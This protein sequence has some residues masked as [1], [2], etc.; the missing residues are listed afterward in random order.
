MKKLLALLAVLAIVLTTCI[1]GI[2][3]VASAAEESPEADFVVFDGILEEYLGVGGDVVIPASLG[4]TEIAADC[5]RLCSEI[6]SIVIPEGVEVIGLRAFWTCENLQS[7]T[8]PYSLYEIGQEAFLSSALTEITIP[9]QVEIV[10]YGCF[11]GSYFLSE[12]KFSYGVERIHGGAFGGSIATK[13]IFP[14]TVEFIG[15]VA[16]N[17]VR[18]N[19]KVEWIICNPD[20]EIGYYALGAGLEKD[21]A[22]QNLSDRPMRPINNTLHPGMNV[23]F[24]VPRDSAIG[25]FIDENKD[26]MLD[27]S[28]QY[29]DAQA[30]AGTTY[31]VSYKDPSYFKDLEENQKGYGIKEP[32]SSGNGTT[33]DTTPEQGDE[34]GPGEEGDKGTSG[35]NSN[36]NNNNKNNGGN[37]TYIEQEKDNSS[38][39]MVLAIVGGVILLIIIG[40]VVFLVIYM[41]KPKA[42]A[43]PPYGYPPYGYPPVGPDGQPIQYAPQAPVAPAP[44]AAP[45]A[46]PVEEAPV[47]ETP[48]EE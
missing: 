2:G 17:Y 10:P 25:K 44:E 12:I 22:N 41:K 45:E 23:T 9:P 47:D 24:T 36:K 31:R 35:S 20:C 8:L 6:T 28:N 33:G 34:Y 15:G 42:P 46:A 1:M 18:S 7:V 14:E 11:Q 3:T 37:T 5:F 43:Y 19:G 26:I 48:T 27:R 29:G 32:A 16:F 21:W 13:V 39:I 30:G 4:V 38:M 40:V